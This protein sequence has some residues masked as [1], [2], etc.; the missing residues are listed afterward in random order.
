V[1]G[2]VRQLI[3]RVQARMP[4]AVRCT[5]NYSTWDDALRDS[6]GYADPAIL[7]RT[8]DAARLVRDGNAAFERDGVAFADPDF[9]W[10]VLCALYRHAARMDRLHVLDFGG[11]LGSIYHQHRM[12]LEDLPRVRWAVVEQAAH[13]E[14][15]RADFRTAQLD[16]YYTIDEALANAPLD[17]LLLSGVLQALPTPYDFIAD[18]VERRFSTIILDRVPLMEDDTTRLTVQHVPRRIYSASYPAWFLS[19]T[20]LLASFDSLY[21]LVA[22]WPGFDR[23]QPRGGIARHRGFLF[24]LQ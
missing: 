21:R 16:F 20:R 10:P 14:A 7:R 15:G 8:V 5:G 1:K 6:A 2:R 3:A 19:E 12:L 17:A 18:A 24:E 13:V 9:R 23:V 11:A 22:S 4:S